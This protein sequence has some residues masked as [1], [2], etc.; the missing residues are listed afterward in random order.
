MMSRWIIHVIHTLVVFPA[1]MVLLI[2]KEKTSET[3]QV[4]IWIMLFAM[5]FYHN[6]KLYQIFFTK[7]KIAV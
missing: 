2:E 1:L 4:A 3:L 6:F 7:N 5:L